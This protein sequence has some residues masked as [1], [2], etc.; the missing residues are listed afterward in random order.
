[1]FDA[2][3]MGLFNTA[4]FVPP[5]ADYRV[6][7]TGLKL[8]EVVMKD[9]PNLVL[10]INTRIEGGGPDVAGK[11]ISCQCILGPLS[12]DKTEFATDEEGTPLVN[13]NLVAQIFHAAFGYG[14]TKAEDERFAS[15]RD[16]LDLSI[17]VMNQKLTGAG[18]EE[19]KGCSFVSTIMQRPGKKEGV[20]YPDFKSI[21]PVS[22]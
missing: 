11:P 19:L 21:R 7:V 16:G 18:W 22:N 6:R 4:Y 5:V 13:F 2:L 10:K 17:D 8:E 9:V 1:M 12:A 14:N 3:K 15:E 20:T